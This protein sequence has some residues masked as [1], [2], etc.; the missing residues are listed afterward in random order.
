MIRQAL[1]GTSQVQAPQQQVP[2]QGQG[3]PVG[4]GLNP[5]DAMA[6]LNAI[7]DEGTYQQAKAIAVHLAPQLAQGLPPHY[8]PQVIDGFK[9]QIMQEFPAIAKQMQQIQSA[10]SGQPVPQSTAP[11]PIA[12]RHPPVAKSRAPLSSALKGTK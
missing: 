3:A 4:Q 1:Q 11:A 10:Q 9:Q 2:Q 5:Q 7:H 8:D 6:L 12:S